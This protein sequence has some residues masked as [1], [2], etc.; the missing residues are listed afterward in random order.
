MWGIFW[1]A[2]QEGLSSMELVPNACEL[3]SQAW[4]NVKE[5]TPL[6]LIYCRSANVYPRMQINLQIMTLELK[7]WQIGYF[8]NTRKACT[9]YAK[10]FRQSMYVSAQAGRP[11]NNGCI[12]VRD[13]RRFCPPKLLDRLWDPSGLLQRWYSTWGTRTFGGMRRQVRGT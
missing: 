7:C 4:L 12:R 1:L 2:S 13:K 6:E 10:I 9:L 8:V 11:R 5:E 3:T